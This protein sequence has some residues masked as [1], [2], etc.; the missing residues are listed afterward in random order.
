MLEKTEVIVSTSVDI[1]NV[2]LGL[3]DTITSVFSNVYIG[4]DD[5]ITSVFPNVYLRLND[6]STSVF[7][8]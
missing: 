3:Y 2:H 6:T 4:L 1:P 5:T 8:K 7:S